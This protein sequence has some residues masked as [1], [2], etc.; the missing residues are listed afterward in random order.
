MLAAYHILVIDLAIYQLLSSAAVAMAC[1]VI[2]RIECFQ[3]QII[4]H[5]LYSLLLS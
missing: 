4:V 3:A 2:D 5:A 1:Y